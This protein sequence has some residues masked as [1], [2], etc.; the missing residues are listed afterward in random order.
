MYNTHKN[1]LSASLQFNYG[2]SLIYAQFIFLPQTFHQ[3]IFYTQ[4]CAHY[5]YLTDFIYTLEMVKWWLEREG[6]TNADYCNIVGAATWKKI[7][8]LQRARNLL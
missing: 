6:Q 4:S 3:N 8:M 2:H 7:L 1:V 5:A